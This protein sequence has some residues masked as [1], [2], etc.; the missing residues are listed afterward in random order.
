MARTGSRRPKKAANGYILP[1][2][3]FKQRETAFA[4][5]RDM[6]ENRSMA[7]LVDAFAK[8]QP[9]W[10]V[11]RS[12]LEKWSRMHD[13]SVRV[14]EHDNAIARGRAQGVTT[15]STLKVAADPEFNQIDA[16]LR[17]ANQ[18]LTKAMSANPVVTRPGDVKAL[19]DAAAHAIALTEKIKAQSSG[20]VSAQQVLG[21]WM[22]TRQRPSEP[23]G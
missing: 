8:E 20:K 21:I 2:D 5:Y 17:A 10:A 15:M 3:K 14:K 23:P 7:R 4:I 1:A 6:G 9:A 18:S 11:T 19:V 16:L 13:W 12:T 22:V